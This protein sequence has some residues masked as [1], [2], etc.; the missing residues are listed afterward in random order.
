[1]P[2]KQNGPGEPEASPN[3]QHNVQARKDIMRE[4]KQ[5]ADD[6]DK[7][8]LD[9]NKIMAGVRE[10]LREAGI[11]VEAFNYARKVANRDS[12]DRD[13][14]LE[15]VRESLQALGV[16]MQGTFFPDAGDRPKR[17]AHLSEVEGAAA[18]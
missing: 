13:A 8:R 5:V 2:K 15:N 4:C 3:T 16:G 18:H 17:P 1:M 9:Q 14:Y 7:V 6:V 12:D 11:S 10:R